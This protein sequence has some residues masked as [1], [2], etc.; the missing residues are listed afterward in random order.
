MKPPEMMQDNIQ[1]YI[2]DKKELGNRICHALYAEVTKLGFVND[3][4]DNIRFDQLSFNLSRD[5][6]AKQNSLECTWK[7]LRNN[8]VG[9]IVF[10]GDGSFYAEYD[11]IQPHPSNKHWFIEAIEAWGN[12]ST[13]KTELKLLPTTK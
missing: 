6:F 11:V 8:R 10:H 2:D 9:S 7:G 1:A 13:I 12:E 3:G 4:Y 5:S